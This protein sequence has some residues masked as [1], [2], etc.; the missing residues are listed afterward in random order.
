MLSDSALAIRQLV[1][2]DLGVNQDAR[3]AAWGQELDRLRALVA[4]ASLELHPDTATYTI[5]DWERVYGLTDSGM[6][7]DHRRQAVRAADNASGLF[8]VQMIKAA[9]Y[10]FVGYEVEVEEYAPFF[11]EDDDSLTTDS[12]EEGEYYAGGETDVYKITVYIDPAKV[13]T[14]GFNV[15]AMQKAIERIKHA[16][17][18]ITIDFGGDGF[19]S[20]DDNS[21][22]E[23]T[24]TSDE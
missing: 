3:F 18:D 14:G 15:L 22:T 10:P 12:M 21:L 7:L 19:Y 2:L 17:L 6:P 16:H 23:L 4:E 13:T 5:A 8:T 20:E 9:L 11:S 24:L 1:P